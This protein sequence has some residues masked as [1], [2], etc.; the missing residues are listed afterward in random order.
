MGEGEKRL[1]FEPGHRANGAGVPLDRR[2]KIR[3]NKSNQRRIDKGRTERLTMRPIRFIHAADLHL[4]SPFKGLSSLPQAIRRAVRESTFAALNR[5]VETAVAEQADFVLFA[6]DIYDSADRSL[7]AQFRFQRAVETL[8][9]HGIGVYIV[10]GN[11]DPENGLQAALRWPEGTCVFPSGEA[12]PCAVFSDPARGDLAYI[13]GWSYPSSA[14]TENPLRRFG[15]PRKGALN[16]GLL[17][18]NVDGDP[19]HDNYAPC[20][21]QELIAAGFD[22]WALGHVHGRRVLHEDPYIVYPGNLQGRSV[23]ETGAKGCYVVDASESGRLS[24]RFVPTDALRWHQV[25]VSIEGLASEQELKDVL[26]ER[27][28]ECE[29]AADGRPSLVRFQLEGRGPLHRRLRRSSMLAEL[30]EELREAECVRAETDP[31]APFVWIESVTVQTGQA[32]DLARIAS[33][34]PF[35]G[36]LI[37]ISGEIFDGRTEFEAFSQQSLRALLE[38]PKAGAVLAEMLAREGGDWL[39]AAKELAVSSVADEEGWDEN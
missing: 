7:R 34:H 11:H 22:Y 28:R 14:V 27:M 3:L 24:L 36:D 33:R 17:H 8:R 10:H 38:H 1:F 18:A 23:R 19:E 37:R 4:D 35:L 9:E 26:E 21:R 12:A 25:A 5:L 15:K 6:G 29:D 16:I 39:K 20:S 31:D 32:L 13:H 30:T 2:V